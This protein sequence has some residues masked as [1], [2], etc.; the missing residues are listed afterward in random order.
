MSGSDYSG[1]R[2]MLV[3]QSL[4]VG[5]AENMVENL[6]YALRDKGC[7]IEVVALQAGETIV[8]ERLR[9][10]GMAPVFIGKHRGPDLTVISR[11]SDEMKRFSPDVV[12]SHLPILHYVNPAAWR[13][14]T[15]NRV[16]TIHSVAQ[17]ETGSRFKLAYAKYCYCKRLVRP[18]ALSEINRQTVVDFYG[19]PSDYV[20]VV[21]NGVDLSRFTPKTSYAI[22]GVP[23]I[24]HVGRFQE[25]KN[26]AAIIEAASLLKRK[27]VSVVFDLYGEGGLM[28]AARAQVEDLG[29]ADMVVF[30]GLTAD[31]PRA[32]SAADIFVLPSLWE[33][34]PMV[35]AEAMAAGL[36]IVASRV[37]GIPDMI[38]D[39][40]DGV[41]CEPN[42][43]S[44]A[45]R[46]ERL[47]SDARLRASI[48][49][50]ARE[51]SHLFSSS[52]M[53]ERYLKVYTEN[54]RG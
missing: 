53:A 27:G 30:H 12:H 24:C 6:A 16:H 52:L 13:M 33:G 3:V 23:H 38:A 4:R 40:T 22:S 21:P 41:L 34:I 54:A 2:V 25:A 10:N 46:I 19:I 35:I 42:G 36:P 15:M 17:K 9:V 8:S 32:M 49:S 31:V 37:G 7:T 47:I 43:A 11:L 26:H 29:I 48:G 18:V 28:E 1:Y 51:K 5:G 44:L 45:E 50:A 14:H 39:G 20:A